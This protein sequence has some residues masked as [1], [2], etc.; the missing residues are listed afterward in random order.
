MAYDYLPT[1]KNFDPDYSYSV[2]PSDDGEERELFK[3]S[4]C[5][6]VLRPAK[7]R[8]IKAE[9]LNGDVVHQPITVNIRTGNI[10]DGNHRWNAW[11][12]AVSEGYKRPIRVNYVDVPE[13]DEFERF[14][15][16]NSGTPVSAVDVVLCATAVSRPNSAKFIEFAKA[17]APLTWNSR[18]NKVNRGTT[19]CLIFGGTVQAD[20]LKKRGDYRTIT[21]EM[22]TYADKLARELHVL[23]GILDLSRDGSRRRVVVSA[24]F[25]FRKGSYEESERVD[26]I[27]LEKFAEKVKSYATKE[28]GFSAMTQNDWIDAF[29][30][31]VE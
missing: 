31:A 7:V 6:R 9:L 14:L 23:L 1:V 19:E 30:H 18:N 15:K 26:K 5:E 20:Y 2:F 4:K 29:C 25:A 13:E 17:H 21:P 12:E 16:I 8:E 11:L 22:V 10:I 28:Y 24:W 27:G 3:P